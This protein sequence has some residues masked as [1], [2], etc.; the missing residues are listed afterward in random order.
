MYTS[1]WKIAEE[2]EKLKK[3]GQIFCDNH[4]WK[5]NK[6]YKTIQR[7]DKITWIGGTIYRTI[8]PTTHIWLQ[9]IDNP[10]FHVWIE[11]SGNSAIVKSGIQVRI[12]NEYLR[13][14]MYPDSDK[15]RDCRYFSDYSQACN[16]ILQLI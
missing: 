7:P 8:T 15:F 13:N 2:R 1:S 4:Q 5:L 14:L 3:P 16:Y 10:N 12:Q 9:S 6:K 11:F